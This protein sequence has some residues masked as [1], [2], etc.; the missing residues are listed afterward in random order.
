MQSES[1]TID[2]RI[3]VEINNDYFM[4]IEALNNSLNTLI[5]EYSKQVKIIEIKNNKIFELEYEYE[6]LKKQIT[7]L[8]IRLESLDLYK[9]QWNEQ[10]NTQQK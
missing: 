4:Q 6:Y 1:L 8:N 2:I 10:Y 3:Q 5:T 9:K 7:D